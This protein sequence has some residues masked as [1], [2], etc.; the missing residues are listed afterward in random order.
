MQIKLMFLILVFQIYHFPPTVYAQTDPYDGLLEAIWLDSLTITAKKKGFDVDN[1]IEMVRTDTSFYQAFKNLRIIPHFANHK[2]EFFNEKGKTTE[3]YKA[4]TQLIGLGNCKEIKF[5]NLEQSPGYAKKNGTRKYITAKLYER[6]FLPGGTICPTEGKE[7]T[8]SKN[9]GLLDYYYGELKQFIFQPGEKANIPLIGNKTALFSE[10]MRKFYDYGIV[11]KN[12]EDGTPC[13]V[14]TIRQ[15]EKYN[16]NKNGKTVIKFMETY[17]SRKDFQVMGRSYE[18]MYPGP[19]F[20]FKIKVDVALE[21]VGK[22]QYLPKVIQYDGNWDI[23]A[24]KREI[25]RFR[26]ELVSK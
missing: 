14:F 4:K 3:F 6:V 17:F 23:P 13:Y 25:G 12:Y 20:N 5:L 15:K 2:Q 11:S 7:E 21:Y 9:D 24:R 18:V 22:K 1:F 8:Y 10:R 19:L 26:M 16:D